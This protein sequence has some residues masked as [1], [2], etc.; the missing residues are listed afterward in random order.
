M[1]KIDFPFS[2]KCGGKFLCTV[3]QKSGTSEFSG[4]FAPFHYPFT[5]FCLLKLW[6]VYLQII[7]QETPN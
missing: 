6:G 5:R 4:T 2:R 7:G 3:T 1:T